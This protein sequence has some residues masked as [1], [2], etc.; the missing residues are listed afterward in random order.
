MDGWAKSSTL[1]KICHIYYAIMK[2]SIFIPH[3]KKIQKI[4]ESSDTP[5]EFNFYDASKNGYSR[6]C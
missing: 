6:P 4:N 5:L 2:L 3:L 1:P